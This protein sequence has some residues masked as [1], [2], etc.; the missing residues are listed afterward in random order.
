MRE[1]ILKAIAMY[2][3]L[4]DV[5]RTGPKSKQGS[6]TAVSRASGIHESTLSRFKRGADLTL[7]VLEQ[8][9]D[10]LGLELCFKDKG[11]NK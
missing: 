1:V 11:I 6:M 8:L 10:T 2:P 3:A 9:C 7:T 4:P 5:K